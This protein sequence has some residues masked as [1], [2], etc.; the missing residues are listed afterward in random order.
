MPLLAFLWIAFALN[1]LDR[2]MVYSMLPALKADL[3]FEG[4]RLGL[5]GTVF[6]WVY[7]ITMPLAGRMAD[8]WRRDILIT[9]SLVLWSMAALGCGF[10]RSEVSFLG[11]RG[12]MAVTESLYYPA[13]LAVIASNYAPA[14]RS[15]ALGIHQSAQLFGAVAGGW[16]GGW[17]A[18]NVGWR[19][20]FRIAAVV[21]IAYGGVLW[22]GVQRSKQYASAEAGRSSVLSSFRSLLRSRAYVALCFAFSA[23]CA[24][25]WI[26]FA[27]FP[28]FLQERFGLSMTESGWNGTLFIQTSA[29]VGIVAGGIVTD[30]LRQRWPAAR[31]HVSAAGV[32]LSAPFAFLTFSA[33]SLHEARVFSAG[34]G[35]FGGLLAAN[36]FAA[37]YDLMRD[38][39]HGLAGG[40]LNMTGG[41]SSGATIYAAGAW[42]ESIGFSG[43][44]SVVA[45]VAVGTALVLMV[46]S[47]RGQA[48]ADLPP[49]RSGA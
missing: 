35:V 19:E 14:V 20:G 27:W 36:A 22:W 41:I 3:G 21:G 32:L 12:V 34:F 30:K 10:A 8:V 23:F 16:Y 46:V 47:H 40:I 5:I 28:T 9:S 15:R 39:S 24:M 49:V 4:A 25:Q 13:A 6:Q 44:M 7:T 42:K 26:F 45:T 17:A 33:D 37:A 31:L 2:Q 48:K 29:I 43:L 18:D 38:N 1:Y 11:W